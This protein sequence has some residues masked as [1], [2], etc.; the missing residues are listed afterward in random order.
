MRDINFERAAYEQHRCK[1]A[2]TKDEINHRLRFEY[3]LELLCGAA[4]VKERV[5]VDHTEG[6]VAFVQNK[7]NSN[8]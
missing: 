7:L 3:L 4:Q 5:V 1:V 8:I 6:N 2:G